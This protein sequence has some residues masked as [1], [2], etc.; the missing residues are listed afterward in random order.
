MP[1]LLLHR[2]LVAAIE[3]AR[4]DEATEAMLKVITFEQIL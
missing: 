1:F 2:D 4:E 3:R